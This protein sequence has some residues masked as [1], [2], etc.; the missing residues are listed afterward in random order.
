MDE[1][2]FIESNKIADLIEEYN[3]S[4]HKYMYISKHCDKIDN[5]YKVFYQKGSYLPSLNSKGTP[6]YLVAKINNLKIKNKIIKRSIINFKLRY[7]NKFG[8]VVND[9]GL[10]ELLISSIISKYYENTK[11]Y[12]I[13]FGFYKGFFF[14]PLNQNNYKSYVVMEE[15][16]DNINNNPITSFK[17]ARNFLLQIIITILCAQ[18]LHINHNDMHGCNIMYKIITNED[19]YK[20]KR[21]NEY[22]HFKY[23]IDGKVYYIQNNKV[24]FK[25]MDLDFATKFGEKGVIRDDI[26]KNDFCKDY[27]ICN[28]FTTSYDLLMMLSVYYNIAKKNRIKGIEILCLNIL[29]YYTNA[30]KF[31]DIY[32]S[33]SRPLKKYSNID[34]QDIID[35]FFSNYKEK[36][37][38]SKILDVCKF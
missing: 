36:P 37:H 8:I 15:I 32:N 27:D 26:K 2:D 29:K 18:K 35:K 12:C 31:N 4:E 33:N 17:C 28:K 11:K 10:S 30:K 21:I 16:T 23:I 25:Y 9:G 38:N 13:N 19:K 20:G 6:K 34:M 24:L 1:L 5:L 3:K 7:D 22:T 14:C